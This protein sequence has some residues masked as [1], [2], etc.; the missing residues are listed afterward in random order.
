MFICLFICCHCYSAVTIFITLTPDQWCWSLLYWTEKTKLLVITAACATKFYL[1]WSAINVII[2]RVKWSK[3]AAVKHV[4]LRIWK[5]KYIL[6]RLLKIK[7]S[8]TKKHRF[9]SPKSAMSIGTWNVRTV[10][11]DSCRSWSVKW[12]CWTCWTCWACLKPIEK[13]QKSRF[14]MVTSL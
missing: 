3:N 4:Y 13:V 2:L 14:W 11:E 5:L 1:L 10:E 6:F 7:Q 9:L 8:E 12:V